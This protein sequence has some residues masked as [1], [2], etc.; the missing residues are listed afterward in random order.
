MILTEEKIGGGAYGE[1]RVATFRGIRVAAKCLHDLIVSDYNRALFTREMEIS[2]RIHHPNILEEKIL[3]SVLDI[4]HYH[5]IMFCAEITN[6]DLYSYQTADKELIIL[7]NEQFYILWTYGKT[8]SHACTVEYTWMHNNQ[9][10]IVIV[11]L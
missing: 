5:W 1:V 6:T 2:S 4:K 3:I 8:A 9:Q 10:G 11:P 7:Y